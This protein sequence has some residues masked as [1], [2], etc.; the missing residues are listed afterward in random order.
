VSTIPFSNFT[1]GEIAPELQARIDT[2]QYAS[3]ARR[4]RNFIIQRYGGLSFRPGFRLVGEADSVDE[5]TRYIPFQYNMEQ[6]YMM[7]FEDERARLMAEGGFIVEDD[8]QITAITNGVNA[9]LTVAYHDYVVGDRLVLNGIVGMVEL[10]G[11]TARVMSVPDANNF[12]I[13]VDTTI[14]SP[15]ISSTGTTRVATPTP[16]PPDPPAPTP[17]PPPP[18]PPPVVGGGG[19]GGRIGGNDLREPDGYE[20]EQ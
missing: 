11:R 17:P 19:T 2:N 5:K 10:N 12:T 4:V 20:R 18:P 14:Y 9:Q 3:A 16:P 6:A 15:F 13:D 8:L 7:S 1:K